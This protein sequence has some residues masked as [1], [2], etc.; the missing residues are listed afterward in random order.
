MQG[1]QECSTFTLKSDTTKLDVA[2]VK[3]FS[4]KGGM[5]S[6]MNSESHFIV[7]GSD[8]KKKEKKQKKK[9]KST[10]KNTGPKRLLTNSLVEKN[11]RMKIKY[12]KRYHWN[13]VLTM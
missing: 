4:V 7:H 1:S 9:K 5:I 8:K 12:S 13:R 3:H 10:T 2:S 11:N 6:E